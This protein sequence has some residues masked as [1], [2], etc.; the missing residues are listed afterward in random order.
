M[1]WLTS[2]HMHRLE[3]KLHTVNDL[4][5]SGTIDII[6]E[7]TTVRQFAMEDQEHEKYAVANLYRQMLGT[8]INMMR[9][10]SGGSVE[11]FFIGMHAVV[12]Y[13]GIAQCLDG[14]ITPATVFSFGIYNR[15]ICSEIRYIFAVLIPSMQ[16]MGLPLGLLCAVL[17]A[18]GSIEPDRQRPTDLASSV[19]PDRSPEQQQLRPDKFRGHIVFKDAHFRYPT[20][21]QKPVLQGISFEVQ[22]GEKVAFVGKTGCGK[23]TCVNLMLRMYDLEQ[24]QITIDGEPIRCYGV[25]HLR[26]NIGVVSQDNVLFSMSIRENITYGMGQGHLPIPSDDEIMLACERANAMS[27]L[28]SCTR[29]LAREVSDYQAASSSGLR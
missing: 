15:E 14:S 17:G 11:A 5:V 25:H 12:V 18:T 24:G 1:I 16:T 19:D 22:P 10:L 4:A 21:L 8:R 20:E 2:K 27:S 29:W 6:K 9:R 28:T 13:F 7:L 3:Q 23:S 26:R